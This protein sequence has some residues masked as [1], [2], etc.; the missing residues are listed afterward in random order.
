MNTDIFTLSSPRFA[1]EKGAQQKNT[2]I[3]L[4][5]KNPYKDEQVKIVI[6]SG[7]GIK[8]IAM[9]GKLHYY[10]EKGL[11][12][13]KNENGVNTFCGTSIGSVICL[14]MIC[15]YSPMEIFSEVYTMDSFFKVNDVQNIWDL[16]KNF[17]LMSINTFINKIADLVKRKFKDLDGNAYIP[18]LQQLKELT[19]K[20]LMV[21]ATNVS[22]MRI[23]YF[24]PE[25]KPNLGSVD[26]SKISCNLPLIFQRILYNGDYYVDGGIL[27]N[28]P[29]DQVKDLPGRILGIIV[30]GTD[31][32]DDGSKILHYLY[33][34]LIMPINMITELR[35]YPAS[36]DERV[37]LVKTQFDNIPL[38][39]FTMSR[40]KKTEM[41]M[42]GYY[43][44][45]MEDSKQLFYVQEWPPT[46]GTSV[47]KRGISSN[48]DN[49]VIKVQQ[50][51]VVDSSKKHSLCESYHN[52]QTSTERN[53]VSERG[54]D[55]DINGWEGELSDIEF[56]SEFIKYNDEYLEWG[57]DDV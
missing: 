50:E 4:P 5:I 13:L 3:P 21:T 34:L 18:S 7:G 46:E 24:T 12:D 22:K 23:E 41:F 38:L 55:S 33:R 44:A 11:L 37:T 8:G 29:Y 53:F 30:T 42:K 10:Y 31:L 45:K 56:N 35:A 20:T 1:S 19:G 6:V 40:E 17:G 27:D 51:S 47:S 32:T 54:S 14:L 57:W 15:G 52:G 49:D 28:F 2:E 39:E 25:S 48:T 36:L 43:T 9:L 26:A 16:F